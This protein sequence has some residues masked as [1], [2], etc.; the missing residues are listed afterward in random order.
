MRSYF[1]EPEVLFLNLYRK[2][3]SWGTSSRLNEVISGFSIIVKKNFDKFCTKLTYAAVSQEVDAELE[4]LTIMHSFQCNR[5]VERLYR[6]LNLTWL[7]QKDTSIVLWIYEKG[8]KTSIVWITRIE[9]GLT[10][11][12]SLH[13]P[14][15]IYT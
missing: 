10:F 1:G 5:L 12:F 14:I 2:K 6:K 8:M 13:V 7:R 3:F 11:N 15:F 9:W 4:Q